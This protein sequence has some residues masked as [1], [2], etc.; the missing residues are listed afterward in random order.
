MG[1]GDDQD[2]DEGTRIGGAAPELPAAPPARDKTDLG[3]G[4][5]EL[6][7]GPA[8][9]TSPAAP[10]ADDDADETRMLGAAEQLHPLVMVDHIEPPG[11]SQSVTLAG[12]SY[13]IGRAVTCD[14]R[15]FSDTAS[16]EHARLL[17]RA[18][19]WVL[20]PSEGKMVLANGTVVRD[21]VRLENRMLLQL[22]GD[23]LRVIDQAAA[24]AAAEPAPAPVP[25]PPSPVETPARRWR[26]LAFVLVSAAV[27]AAILWAW[28]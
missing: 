13:V 27:L 3:L 24:L 17:R 18:D 22:G 1:D 26:W 4:T 10:V 11:H 23:Q 19:A 6:P 14:I 15:L 8:P 12:A 7:S 2:R 21:E 28:R 20:V 16:R 25:V 5:P 9:A